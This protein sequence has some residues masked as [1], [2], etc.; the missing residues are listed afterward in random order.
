MIEGIEVQGVNVRVPED[1]AEM[2]F[3][4]DGSLEVR[5]DEVMTVYESTKGFRKAPET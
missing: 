2:G 3:G 4:I 1:E 5:F